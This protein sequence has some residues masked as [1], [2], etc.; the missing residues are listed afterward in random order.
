MFRD[1]VRQALSGGFLDTWDESS[2]SVR[3]VARKILGVTSRQK[4]IDKETW[5]WNE[6]VQE[7][8]R[9]KRLAKK[10][11]QFRQDE[12]S[13]QKYKEICG[14]TKRAVVKAKEKAYSNPYEKLNSKEGEKDLYRLAR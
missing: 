5:C 1:E 2:N 7:S 4:K 6:K 9:G 11:W 13:R 14:K 10:N 8:S 12:E 3:D